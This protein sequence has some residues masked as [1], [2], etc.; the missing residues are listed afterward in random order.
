MPYE[1]MIVA[2][3]LDGG[4][5]SVVSQTSGQLDLEPAR[6]SKRIHDISWSDYN[7]FGGLLGRPE[8]AELLPEGPGKLQSWLEGLPDRAVLFLIHVAEWETGVQSAP[9]V[10]LG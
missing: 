8:F 7:D 1:T 3:A 4:R 6:R 2:I 9:E 10:A 5:Y